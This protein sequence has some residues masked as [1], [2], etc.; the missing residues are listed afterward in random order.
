[1]LMRHENLSEVVVEDIVVDMVV[2][3]SE[4]Y[5]VVLLCGEIDSYTGPGLR[6]RL[7]ELAEG[8]GRPL[9][10]DMSGVSF[11]DGSALRMLTAIRRQCAERGVA[12]AIVGLRPFLTNLF[13][14]F[15]V[16][17]HIPL[18]TALDEALW[19]LLPPSDDDVHAWLEA[20]D[21][22]G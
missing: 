20:R 19:R 8:A 21:Q 12:L 18:C 13:Q 10:L 3:D 15:G 2:V 14:A 7:L 9:V 4:H 22:A 5:A 11:C 16:H 1:M 17:E 6:S